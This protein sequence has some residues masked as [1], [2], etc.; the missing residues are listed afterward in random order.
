M[1]RLAALA[2][3]L[4]LAL[5]AASAVA[6][7]YTAGQF[8]TLDYPDDLT[9]DNETYTEDTT[10]DYIWLFLL[11]GDITIDAALTPAEG[12]EG[13]N[14]YEATEEQRQAYLD[15]MLDLYAD[16]SAAY[17]DT[18][19]SV[20]GYPFYI[21]S[22]EDS[23]DGPYYYAETLIQGT[24]VNF[25]CYYNDE[26]AGLDQDLLDSF[27]TVLATVR[28]VDEADSQGADAEPTATP[29]AGA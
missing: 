5:S 26:S 25:C 20:G 8:Y 27:M 18:L 13:V 23:E 10:E 14:L 7:T 12:Y 16:D 28:P 2:L 17:V 22:M 6:Q 15:D 4:L 19:T 21:Y 29:E 3:A 9:L 24:S 11:S 1:K